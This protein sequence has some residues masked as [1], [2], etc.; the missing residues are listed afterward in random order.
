MS[1]LPIDHSLEQFYMQQGQ[2]QAAA[3][4]SQLHD[5][6]MM[7]MA[8]A[9]QVARGQAATSQTSPGGVSPISQAVM[10]AKSLAAS[11]LDQ[12]SL[13]DE[14]KSNLQALQNDPNTNYSDFNKTIEALRTGVQGQQTQAHQQAIL[15][16]GVQNRQDAMGMKQREL[17]A[18]TVKQQLDE[19]NKLADKAHSVLASK[20]VNPDE[21][22]SG[23]D[24][25]EI[26]ALKQTYQAN[27]LKAAG[28]RRQQQAALAAIAPQQAG[29]AA[30][31]PA[32]GGSLSVNGQEVQD[33]P[34]GSISITPGQQQQQGGKVDTYSQPAIK[35]GSKGHITPEIAAQYLKRVGGN[36][37]QARQ[38]AQSEGWSF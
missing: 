31:A 14:Q 9:Q 4:Q 38:A 22:P 2:Q 17:Q 21:P 28:L 18:L 37:Q 32:P 15:K 33:E 29:A 36:K 35:P 7:Q 23:D 1:Q 19:V 12:T 5:A 20:N 3:R 11:S 30:P 13:S 24:E 34:S 27:T 10:K 8:Q 16:Q 25:P 26:A 6:N